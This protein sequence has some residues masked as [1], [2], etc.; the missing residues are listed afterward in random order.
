MLAPKFRLV[1]REFSQWFRMRLYELGQ[2]SDD[3]VSL[4]CAGI[5][6]GSEICG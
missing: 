1:L 4:T 3:G 2:P 5:A 6:F